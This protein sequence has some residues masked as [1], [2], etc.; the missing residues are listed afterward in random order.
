MGNFSRLF[1]STYSSQRKVWQ[2]LAYDIKA[3]YIDNGLFK[4]NILTKKLDLGEIVMDSF[5]KRQGKNH[6]TFTRFKTECSNPKNL[7][8]LIVRK[9]FMNKKAPKNTELILTDYEAFDRKYR[10]F[11]SNKR[12]VKHLLNRKIFAKIIE[13]QP[14]RDIRIELKEQ[15][16]EL[17]IASLN[18]DL[19]QLKSLFSLIEALRNHIE[20]DL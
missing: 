5:N 4:A 18:K 6:Q 19:E 1:K 13:Q 10:L 17:Q 3:E 12:D 8:F 7:Q 20:A 2:Q 16:L 9:N 11:G 15:N 14:Y